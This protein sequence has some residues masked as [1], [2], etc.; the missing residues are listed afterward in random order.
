MHKAQFV[1][2][3]GGHVTWVERLCAASMSQQGHPLAIYTYEPAELAKYKLAAE[4]RDAREVAPETDAAHRYHAERRFSMFTET[5]RLA[6]QRQRKGIWVDLDCYM[7]KPL[8]TESDYVFGL[9]SPGKIN[10]AVLR[11]PADCA[12]MNEYV[13]AITADPLHT[14]WSTFRRRVRREVEILLGQS[15]PS[16][17]VRTNIG[18]RAMNYFVRKHGLLKYALPQHAFYPVLNRETALLVE[19]KDRISARLTDQTIIVHLWRGRMA[20]LGILSEL[21]PASSYL[22]KACKRFGL[23]TPI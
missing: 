6:L 10:G 16:T 15:Q 9:A 3:W 1:S 20:H 14:P 5:F 2:F 18:P 7:L 21:P 17:S 22:G 12:M 8:V 13:S 11:L 4:I 23:K 19:P